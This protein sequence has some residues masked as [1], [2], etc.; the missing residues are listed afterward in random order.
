MVTEV[1]QGYYTRLLTCEL[2]NP[3]KI[4]VEVFIE[5]LEVGKY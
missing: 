5:H 3:Q 1:T 2:I 4:N